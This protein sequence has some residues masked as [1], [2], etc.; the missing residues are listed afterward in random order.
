MN[1]GFYSFVAIRGHQGQSDYFLVQ[2]PLWLV[3]RLFLF[4]ELEVPAALRMGR[5]VTAA[6]VAEV[7]RYLMARH[8][9]TMCFHRWWRLWIAM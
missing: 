3:P 9:T 5:T 6:G 2:C 1:A 4:D 8:R 7:A